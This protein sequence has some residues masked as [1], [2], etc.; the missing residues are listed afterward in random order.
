MNKDKGPGRT[1]NF[2]RD[3]KLMVRAHVKVGGQ[4]GEQV[5]GTF[6]KTAE[7]D[8]QANRKRCGKEGSR[9]GWSTNASKCVLRPWRWGD[10]AKSPFYNPGIPPFE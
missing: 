9:P 7:M 2:P 1:K 6:L 10:P 4:C 8:K 3:L 5:Q